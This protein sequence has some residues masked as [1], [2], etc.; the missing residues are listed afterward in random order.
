MIELTVY[1]I[2]APQGSKRFIGHAKSGRGIMVESSKKVKPWREAVK[3]AVIDYTEKHGLQYDINGRLFYGPVLLNLFFTLPKPKSAPK[4]RRT[5]PDKKPDLSKLIRSTED[6]LTDAGVWEDD[7]RVVC[8]L[9]KKLY[10]G[11]GAEA[12]GIPGA[13]IRVSQYLDQ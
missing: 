4:T 7:A 5:F 10:P 1:G 6:A 12:L 9:A 8:C 11:E 2:P 3:S 13:I